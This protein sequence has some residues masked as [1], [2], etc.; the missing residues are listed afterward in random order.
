MLQP[1]ITI[2]QLQLHQLTSLVHQSAHRVCI[3]RWSR[4]IDLCRLAAAWFVITRRTTVYEDVLGCWDD[5][6]DVGCGK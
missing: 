6:T 3:G 1:L 5:T 4:Y 2:C